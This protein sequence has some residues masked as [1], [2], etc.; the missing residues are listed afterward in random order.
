MALFAAAAAAG[1]FPLLPAQSGGEWG[2]LRT[3]LV[4]LDTAYNLPK[5]P[6]AHGYDMT[7]VSPQR[8]AYHPGL[9]A[10]VSFF[11]MDPDS[12]CFKRH[13]GDAPWVVAHVEREED[14]FDLAVYE[15]HYMTRDLL[16]ASSPSWKR[17]GFRD[18]ERALDVLDAKVLIDV[19]ANLGW[20]SFAFAT[21]GRKSLMIEPFGPNVDLLNTSFCLNPA[22]ERYIALMPVGLGDAERRCDLYQL[23]DGPNFGDAQAV[24]KNKTDP[25]IDPSLIKQ[26][27]MEMFPLDDVIPSE[28]RSLPK[29]VRVDLGQHDLPALRG[30]STLLQ[31]ELQRP[32]LVQ[33]T[34]SPTNPDPADPA[35]YIK[36]MHGFGYDPHP[37]SKPAS[38]WGKSAPK[39]TTLMANLMANMTV[40]DIIFEREALRDFYGRMMLMSRAA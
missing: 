26:G 38:P 22:R 21:R 29:V 7:P 2:K 4:M 25:S 16:R 17:S 20:N 1:S 39:I 12:P 23:A 5:R 35:A 18:I 32:F 10:N 9:N 15:S 19:G 30:M 6:D 3:P 34:F 27:E 36:L 24:C 13:M 31:D 28:F 37:A 33:V 8:L 40:S 11:R 14:A